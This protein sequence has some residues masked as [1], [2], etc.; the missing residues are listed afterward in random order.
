VTSEYA[1]RLS[2]KFIQAQLSCFLSQNNPR[3]K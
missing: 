1:A 3:K 2:A